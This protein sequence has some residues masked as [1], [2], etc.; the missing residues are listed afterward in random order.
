MAST[1]SPDDYSQLAKDS[2]IAGVLGAGAMVSRMLL[3]PTPVSWGWIIRRTIAASVVSIFVG[4]ALQSQVQS[5]ALRYA[6]IGLAGAAA[7]EVMDAA[8]SWL[9]GKMKTE[10]AKVT[11]GTKPNAKPNRKKRK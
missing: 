7:P 5:V 2:I 3:N 11:R 8:L 4:F 6:G 9:Q 10:V 1:S